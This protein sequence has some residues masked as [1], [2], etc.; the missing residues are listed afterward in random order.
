LAQLI[1]KGNR[2][3]ITHGNGP[4]VGHILLQQS[5][6]QLAGTPSMPL[7]VCGAMSQGFIGYMIQQALSNELTKLGISKTVVTLISQVL[8]DEKDLAFKNPTK[9]IGSFYTWEEAKAAQ[10]ETGEIWKEDSGRGWRRVVAS[11]QPLG[12]IEISAVKALL[13]KDMVVIASGGGGIPVICNPKGQLSG[14]DAVIDKDMAAYKLA[15]AIGADTLIILTDVSHVAINYNTPQ[16]EKLFEI[17]AE[18]LL[19]Y[20]NEGHFK[21]GSMGPKVMA[22]VRF[23]EGEGKRAVITS[24]DNV[25]SGIEVKT[26]TVVTK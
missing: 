9:P 11:P 18:E 17:T 16:E 1:A 13:E 5:Q 20:Y 8:V 2:L 12:L 25:L 7:F 6:G 26:G 3:V 22:S 23:V 15:E 10:E 24:L 4:Q 19:E 21:D 14:I